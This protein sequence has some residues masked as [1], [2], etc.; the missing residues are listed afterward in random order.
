MKILYNFITGFKD[1]TSPGTG[2]GGDLQTTTHYYTHLLHYYYFLQNPQEW[3]HF[4]MPQG[5]LH[6]SR[7]SVLSFL[8]FLVH[9]FPSF[10]EQ[11]IFSPHPLP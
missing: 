8:I 11:S 6:F 2:F 7:N 4:L 9:T 1:S 5:F 10:T 3:G